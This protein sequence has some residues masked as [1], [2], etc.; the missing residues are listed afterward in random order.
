MKGNSSQPAN[1]ALLG[2][3]L[4]FTE[5]MVSGTEGKSFWIDKIEITA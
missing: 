2:D 3:M 4:K 1:K 5:L